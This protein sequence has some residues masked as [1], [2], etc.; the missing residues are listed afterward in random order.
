MLLEKSFG[1]PVYFVYD[2]IEHWANCWSGSDRDFTSKFIMGIYDSVFQRN[3]CIGMDR[4]P[5]FK[6][7]WAGNSYC[8]TWQAWCWNL[9]RSG[10]AIINSSSK[11]LNFSLRGSK[12]NLKIKPIGLRHRAYYIMINKNTERNI[13]CV[14]FCQFKILNFIWIDKTYCTTGSI[15]IGFIILS[16]PE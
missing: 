15:T 2:D 7:Q 16:N 3:D 8:R 14:A 5:I 10:N 4:N 6:C 11:I 13:N 1:Q 12:F 9:Q